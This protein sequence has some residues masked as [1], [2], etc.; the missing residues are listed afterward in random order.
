MTQK[1]LHQECALRSCDGSLVAVA[2]R[3][4]LQECGVT[5]IE[6]MVVIAI[7]AILGSLAAPAFNDLILKN[8]L[9][10]MGSDFAVSAQLARSEAIKRNTTVTLCRSANG[11]S[12]AASGGWEQGWVLLDGAT[13]IQKHDA[14]AGGFLLSSTVSS[15][16]FPSS[17]IRA[18][19]SAITLTLCRATPSVGNKRR[20]IT[21][22]L[23][24]YPK[25]VEESSSV[26]A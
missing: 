5:L 15:I 6:L 18:T 24:G 13:V 4:R 25:Q 11:T 17:G 22:P 9:S 8:R 19:G 20:V 16:D 3:R 1:V 26:C 21:I 10:S 14:L 7:A 2:R 12:C 23:N